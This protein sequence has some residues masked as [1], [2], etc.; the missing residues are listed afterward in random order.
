MNDDPVVIVGCSRTPMGSFQGVFSPVSATR[1]ASVAIEGALQGAG[2]DSSTVEQVLM[3]CVLPAGLGQA[4]ARQAS[5]GA[6]LGNDVPCTTVNKMC[7]SGMQA[8]MLAHDAIAAGSASLVVAGGMESMTNSPYLLEKARQGQR[9]GH[10]EIKDHMFLDGLEDAYEP[11]R[12]MGSF[13]DDTARHFGFTREQQDDYA[14]ESL[15][16]ASRAAQDGSFAREIN[17]VTVSARGKSMVVELDEGP[18]NARPDRISTLKPAFSAD[19][20]VNGK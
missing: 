1:L 6:G 7:G 11:G 9:L 4:P 12:L 14:L 2:V 18:P 16:R 5:L 15:A 20:S 8:A 19:G 17:P 13:A 10:G 3:G